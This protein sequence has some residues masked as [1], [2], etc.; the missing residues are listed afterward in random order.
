MA[1]TGWSWCSIRSN[2]SSYMRSSWGWSG[3]HSMRKGWRMIPLRWLSIGNKTG[4][5]RIP[6]TRHSLSCK[7]SC[8]IWCSYSSANEECCLLGWQCVIQQKCTNDFMEYT[9]P[10]RDIRIQNVTNLLVSSCIQITPTSMVQMILGQQSYSKP[11]YFN[12][13]FPESAMF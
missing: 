7:Q 10:P 11:L 5:W 6:N 12:L 9:A 2:G 13:L 4:T 1:V 3:F 8:D